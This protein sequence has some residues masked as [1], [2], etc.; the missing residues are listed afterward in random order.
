MD[1]RRILTLDDTPRNA[2][3]FASVPRMYGFDNERPG[4]ALRAASRGVQLGP[5]YL[6]R[7]GY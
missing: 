6:G 7:L 4:R 2:D 5:C 3:V 1:Q